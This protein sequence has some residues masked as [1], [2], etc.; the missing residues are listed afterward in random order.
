MDLESDY[1]ENE[2]GNEILDA[3]EYF[4]IIGEKYI[5]IETPNSTYKSSTFLFWDIHIETFSKFMHFTFDFMK[6]I[7]R[8]HTIIVFYLASNS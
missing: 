7:I 3:W 2:G 5:E 8:L 6:L 4:K 1:D